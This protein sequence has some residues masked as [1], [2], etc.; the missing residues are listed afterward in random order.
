MLKQVLGST[1]R[2]KPDVSNYSGSLN[3]EELVD[4]IN[5]M[6]N[7]FDYEEMNDEKKV[8]FTVK[9]LKGHAYLWWDGVQEVLT[10]LPSRGS[11]GPW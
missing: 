5:Y 4:W 7:F 8:K 11:K 3:L 10:T 6:E 1:S 9:K 2:P